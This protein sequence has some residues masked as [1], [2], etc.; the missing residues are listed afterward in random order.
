MNTTEN[1]ILLAEFLGYSKTHPDYPNSTYWYKKGEQPL[2][3]LLF[4]SDWNWLMK[5]VD[6]IESL[7]YD[8]NIKGISCNITPILS[9]EIIVGLVLGDK[10]RKIELVYL[11]CI[12]FVKWYNNKQ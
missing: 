10:S 5:V 8:V 2:S 9:S 6:K 12:E 3:I 4:N 7:G 1:N 11:S